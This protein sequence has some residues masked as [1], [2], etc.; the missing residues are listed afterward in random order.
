MALILATGGCDGTA[1]LDKPV[2]KRLSGKDLDVQ[3]S[4]SSRR[5]LGIPVQRRDL[6]DLSVHLR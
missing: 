5:M 3:P 1:A 6:M 2:A 4:S